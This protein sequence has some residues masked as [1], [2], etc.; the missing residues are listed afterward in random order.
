MAVTEVLNEVCVQHKLKLLSQ[1]VLIRGS[2]GLSPFS[3]T[4]A[5]WIVFVMFTHKVN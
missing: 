2:F 1:A 4:W 3:S 5:S